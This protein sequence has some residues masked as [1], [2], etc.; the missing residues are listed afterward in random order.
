MVIG[1]TAGSFDVT[2]AGHILMF[3]ECKKYCSHLIVCLQSDPTIDRPEKNKPIQTIDERLIILNSIKYIDEVIVYNTEKEL[4]EL[5]KKINPGVRIIGADWKDKDFTGNDLPIKTIFN[6][7]NHKFSSS[8]L[9]ER[10][11]KAEQIKR[12]GGMIKNGR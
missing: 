11:W 8:E 12:L 4:Y 1:V 9:R 5:L 6:S 10:I 3:K 7:R 2:H